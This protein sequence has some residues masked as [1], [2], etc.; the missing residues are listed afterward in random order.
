ML[1]QNSKNGPLSALLYL[2]S[3]DERLS[4]ATTGYIDDNTRLEICVARSLSST[5]IYSTIGDWV[6]G[7]LDNSRHF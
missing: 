2:M 4:N 6:L 7:R 3:A 5:K 1:Q